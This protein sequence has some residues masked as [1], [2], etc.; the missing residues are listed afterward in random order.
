ME[1]HYETDPKEIVPLTQSKANSAR[2]RP[3]PSRRHSLSIAPDCARFGGMAQSALPLA[4]QILEVTPKMMDFIR[5]GMRNQ[6][7]DQL[8]VPQ[9]RVLAKINR[10]QA[11][12]QKEVADWMGITAA[13]LTRM[14]DTLSE[15]GLV[16][17]NSDQRDRRQTLLTVTTSGKKQVEHYRE[18]VEAQLVS[19]IAQLDTTTV[20]QLKTGIKLLEKLFSD[21]LEQ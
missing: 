5:A 2:P 16:K 3:F 7:V 11:I 18:R 13:T 14:I 1:R 21:K 17:R 4:K 19:K 6:A 10:A 20:D 9:F 8:T 15:R 12:S